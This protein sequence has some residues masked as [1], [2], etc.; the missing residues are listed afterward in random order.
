MKPFFND[1]K[2][3]QGFTLIELA[4]VLIIFGFFL[5][6]II[7]AYQHYQREQIAQHLEEDFQESKTII[8]WNLI[9]FQRYPCPADPRLGPGDA[10][11][12]REQRD[13]SDNC[14][15]V[16][17][18]I[19]QRDVDGDG[20]NETVHIGALPI[21]D[22]LDP[23][24]DGNTEDSRID[25]TRNDLRADSVIDPW[26]SKILYAVT[27]EMTK[28]GYDERNGVIDIVNADAGGD[29]LLK[30]EATAHAVIVSFGENR[31][32]AY[33]EG[34]GNPIIN[35]SVG[36]KKQEALDDPMIDN[37]TLTLDESTN[38]NK[39]DGKFLLTTPNDTDKDFYDDRVVFFESA[40][41]DIWQKAGSKKVRDD[42]ISTPLIDE[43][44][45]VRRAASNI[46][47]NVKVGDILVSQERLHVEGDIQAQGVISNRI[48]DTGGSDCLIVEALAGDITDMQC[49]KGQVVESIEKNK[50]NCVNPFPHAITGTCPQPP[51]VAIPEQIVGISS[52]TGIIC[53]P[54]F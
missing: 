18:V 4:L 34:A 22:I 32:G 25:L 5:S 7:F 50:V 49:P 38:C 12:G 52:K 31:N 27:A 47:G 8:D 46:K 54:I 33:V 28:T 43:E 39:L 19:G 20:T 11:Y 23:N 42:D 53:E 45:F 24:N 29:S 37:S 1:N 48:C 14:L 13:T 10:N 41:K 2:Y 16:F 40:F 9:A 6:T 17:D 44:L 21:N 30:E 3:A 35:C 15:N 51:A 26:G 36:V